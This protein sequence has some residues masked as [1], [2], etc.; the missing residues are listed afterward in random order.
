MKQLY[1]IHKAGGVIIQNRK[2]LVERS[3]N[4]QFFIA[5]GGKVEKDET[6]RQALVRELAEEFGIMV[7]E[8]DLEELDTY[9]APAAGKEGLIVRMD[10]FVVKR[11]TGEPFPNSE[12]EEILWIDSRIPKNIRVGSIFDHDVI[13]KLKVMGLI[14]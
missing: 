12:V 1:Q 5:P 7:L 8:S 14:D 13:P 2:L 4:K 10:V 3:R 6:S 11:W 9:Y